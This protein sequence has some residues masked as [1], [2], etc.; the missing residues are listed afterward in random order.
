M[1]V[2][3]LHNEEWGF[4]SNCFVATMADCGS[5]S[6]TARPT[7]P[8]GLLHPGPTGLADTIDVRAAQLGDDA[9]LVGAAGWA[10]A[11][12]SR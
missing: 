9:G 11:T 3:R 8:P 5:H 10:R 12:G 1:T 7:T 6:S 2:R 4:A